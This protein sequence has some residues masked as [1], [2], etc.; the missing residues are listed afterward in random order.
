MTINDLGSTVKHACSKTAFNQCEDKFQRHVKAVAAFQDESED[1]QD[2]WC[3]V[4][5]VN[6]MSKSE[7][8]QFVKHDLA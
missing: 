1:K 4:L 6:T 3:E 5:E 8:G 7:R 2:L